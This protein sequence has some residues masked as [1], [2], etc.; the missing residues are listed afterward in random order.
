MTDPSKPSAPRGFAA[1]DPERQREVSSAGGRAAHQAGRAHRFSSE[2]ARAA[3][4]KGGSAVSEDRRHMA[5]IA[6]RR[7]RKNA[8]ETGE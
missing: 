5:D 7:S 8:P 4:R 1:M 3:G 2:E 6:K